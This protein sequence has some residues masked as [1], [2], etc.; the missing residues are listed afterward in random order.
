[1]NGTEDGYQIRTSMLSKRAL[2]EEIDTDKKVDGKNCKYEDSL[3][4]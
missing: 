1:M 2:Y 3:E 4:P